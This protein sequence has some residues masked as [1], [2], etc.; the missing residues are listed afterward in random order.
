MYEIG[1]S[2]VQ[3][4]CTDENDKETKVRSMAARLAGLCIIQPSCTNGIDQQPDDDN[5]FNAEGPVIGRFLASH[6]EGQQ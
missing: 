1:H 5:W 2:G 6:E 3:I 4:K